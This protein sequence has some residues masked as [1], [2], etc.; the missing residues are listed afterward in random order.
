MT[1]SFQRR[2]EQPPFEQLNIDSATNKLGIQF[3]FKSDG[4]NVET[5]R[6]TIE[7]FSADSGK[8]FIQPIP[9][10]GCYPSAPERIQRIGVKKICFIVFQCKVASVVMT[11]LQITPCKC[12]YFSSALCCKTE[13]AFLQS[14][15][16]LLFREK[17]VRN[18]PNLLHVFGAQEGKQVLM[19]SGFIRR[20]RA[21]GQ[22]FHAKI[23]RLCFDAHFS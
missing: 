5:F 11:F 13:L 23:V 6:N 9:Q 21:V 2:T 16:K 3:L 20:K 15:Q 18:G 22:S 4:G 10:I 17:P 1:K 7:P 14:R 12:C 19:K 8:L